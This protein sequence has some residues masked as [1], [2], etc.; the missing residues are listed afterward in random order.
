MESWGLRRGV[1]SGPTSRTTVTRMRADPFLPLI[2][3]GQLLDFRLVD[4]RNRKGAKGEPPVAIFFTSPLP[5]LI[6]LKGSC[7]FFLFIRTFSGIRHNPGGN[8]SV[9]LAIESCSASL[10]SRGSFHQQ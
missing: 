8:L 3:T 6:L 9:R 7:N 1:Q 4:R 10:F 2:F 5:F